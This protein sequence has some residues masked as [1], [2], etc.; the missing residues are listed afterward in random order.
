MISLKVLFIILTLLTASWVQAD[1]ATNFEDAELIKLRIKELELKKEILE[2]EAKKDSQTPY[3][4]PTPQPYVSPTNSYSGNS[5]PRSNGYIRG[6]R[7]GCYTYSAS[8]NKSYVDRSL[9][10]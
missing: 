8:G 7:G 10:N 5:T 6:P 4:A 9:C 2:L 1:D 3:Q